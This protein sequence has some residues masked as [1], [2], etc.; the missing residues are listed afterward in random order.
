[1]RLNQ[2]R[3]PDCGA[4]PTHSAVAF[5]GGAQQ[6][7]QKA[8]WQIQSKKAC[9]T[10]P[11]LEACEVVVSCRWSNSNVSAV[12]IGTENVLNRKETFEGV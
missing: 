1:M 2:E 12:N 11:K 8:C 6:K 10:D 3:S 4:A 9:W 5:L 7:V